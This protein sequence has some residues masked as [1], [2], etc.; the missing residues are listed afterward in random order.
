MDVSHAK[1]KRKRKGYL[2]SQRIARLSR[3]AQR[4]L[5][6]ALINEPSAARRAEGVG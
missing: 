5:D 3:R 2:A 4:L 1:S 6:K